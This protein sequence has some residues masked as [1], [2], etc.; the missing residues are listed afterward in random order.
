MVGRTVS[1]A[2]DGLAQL[3][4]HDEEGNSFLRLYDISAPWNPVLVELVAPPIG[5]YT[6]MVISGILRD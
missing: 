3:C 4:P 6:E 5:R 2:L 1:P